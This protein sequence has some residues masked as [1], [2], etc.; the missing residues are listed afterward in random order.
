MANLTIISTTAVPNHVR[1]ALSRWMIEPAPGL[2]A[3]PFRLK[4]AR[5][6][7]PLLQHPLLMARQFSYIR[8][9]MN[10]DSPSAPPV[11]AAEP[12]SSWTD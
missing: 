2:Y 3:G 8:Q 9:T 6:S 7:G 10:S 1:G 5:N 4:F 11:N 12:P